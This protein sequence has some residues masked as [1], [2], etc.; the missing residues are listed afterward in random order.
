[1]IDVVSSEL[2]GIGDVAVAVDKECSR[3]PDDARYE[4]AAATGDVGLGE[5]RDPKRDSKPA[6]HHVLILNWESFWGIQSEPGPG[7]HVPFGQP[8]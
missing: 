4:V 8:T 5:S 2:V 7:Q 1:M 3:C 6:S